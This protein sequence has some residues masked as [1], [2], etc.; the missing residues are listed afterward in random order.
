MPAAI[1]KD[2]MQV[3]HANLSPAPL[4]GYIEEQP[5]SADPY[6]VSQ[7]EG[8]DYEEFETPRRKRGFFERLFG[9]SDEPRAEKRVRRQ[10]K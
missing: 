2:V 7:D 1:W 6:L 8:M 3:A 5:E 4:P 10:S 9:G